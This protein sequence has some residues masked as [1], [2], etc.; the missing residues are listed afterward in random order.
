GARRVTLADERGRVLADSVVETDADGVAALR[1][2]YDAPLTGRITISDSAIG[3]APADT[4][5]EL[6]IGT[7]PPS[8]AFLAGLGIV[9]VLSFALAALVRHR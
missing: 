7:R 4:L 2:I 9:M 6:E 1:Y 5:M 3:L 8:I